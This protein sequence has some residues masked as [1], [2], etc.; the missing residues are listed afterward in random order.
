MLSPLIALVSLAL[1]AQPA[2]PSRSGPA[3]PAGTVRGDPEPQAGAALA[4]L[5][6]QAICYGDFIGWLKV[7]AGPGAA[8]VRGD[9]VRRRQA[10]GEFLDLQVLGAEAERKRIQDTQAFQ[11]LDAALKQEC[12]VRVLLDEDRPGGDGRKLREQAEHPT[13]AELLAY[14]EANR[15]RFATPERF[16]VR[17]I[18]SRVKGG[19]GAQGRG[20]PEAQAREK[21]AWLQKELQAGR[22]FEALAR[23][24]SDDADSRADGGRYRDIPF[25]RF[26]LEFEQAVR[27][28]DIGKVG[29]PVRTSFGY[30]LILV[31]SRDPRVPAG[32]AQSRAA[33]RAAMVPERQARLKR[34][35]LDEARREVGF[36]FTGPWARIEWEEERA[37]SLKQTQR[38]VVPGP[39]AYHPRWLGPGDPGPSLP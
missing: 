13:E 23:A 24:Y 2:I 25:G 1:T 17:H 27:T 33:V 39:E 21:I 31:E 30:H 26:P 5:G 19:L 16:T 4:F 37:R 6:Q 28:Q 22:S 29:A 8:Q 11:D 20:L 15:E 14:F 10:I 34:E 35:Y 12:G 36:R 38:E 7:E 9:P 18:L 32:F 3:A